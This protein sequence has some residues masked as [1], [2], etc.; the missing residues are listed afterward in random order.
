M[1]GKRLWMTGYR[2]YE[3]NVFGNQDP[4]LK[5]LKTSL[6]NTL[7][8]F[9]DEGMNWLITGGQLGVEQWAIEVALTLKPLYPE[10][11]IAMMLPFTD[12][13]SKWNEA[14]QGQLAALRQQVDFSDA[15]SQ[16][17]YQRP[18]Q[19]QGYTRFMT[20]HTDA[21]VIVYDPEFPGKPQW[22]YRAAEDMA[23]RR[24]YP[25]TLITMD[26]L[27]DTAQE[28]AEAENEHFQND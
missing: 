16:A 2:A 20:A 19:L 8:Q 25:V 24:D 28:M 5:V 6:K 4:K 12:F 11:K 14:N 13:G 27:E 15:V 23:N 17:P 9:L 7:V 21:A 22:D 10:F 26:D 18:A 3:L 1:A